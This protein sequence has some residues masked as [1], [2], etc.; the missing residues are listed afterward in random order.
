MSVDY[1]RLDASKLVVRNASSNLGIEAL[2]SKIKSINTAS[3][4]V[5]IFDPDGIINKTHIIGAYLNSLIAFKNRSNRT[6]SIALEM[7]LFTAM[8]NQ[9]EKGI[10]IAGAKRSSDFILFSNSAA[11]ARKCKKILKIGKEFQP[12]TSHVKNV[13]K[14][15]GISASDD[16]D[17][18]VLQKIAVSRLGD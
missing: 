1:T 12:S 3:Q 17:A 2:V 16:I 8:T 7:L 11:T 18:A 9:I 5:Q 6:K 4:T 14:K 10:D 13:A 15:F